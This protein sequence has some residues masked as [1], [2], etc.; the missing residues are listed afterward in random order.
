MFACIH[1]RIDRSIAHALRWRTPAIVDVSRT[2][3]YLSKRCLEVDRYQTPGPH[4][5]IQKMLPRMGKSYI[6]IKNRV[7]SSKHALVY[8]QAHA[9]D[10]EGTRRGPL[11]PK[12]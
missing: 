2:K 8:K 11:S 3:F 1:M 5:R 12:V 9:P 10:G 7:S 6:Q 4:V